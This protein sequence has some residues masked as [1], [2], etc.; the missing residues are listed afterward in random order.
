MSIITSAPERGAIRT[1]ILACGVFLASGTMLASVG[2]C[3][4]FLS[5]RT[6]QDLASLSW[7]FTAFSGGV[8]LM[9]VGFGPASDRL[10]LRGVL[11]AGMALMGGGMLWVTLATSLLALLAAAGLAGVGFGGIIAAG[12]LLVAHMFEARSATALNGV[13]VFFGVGAIVGPVIVG[14]AGDRLGL[15]QVALWAGS[16]LILIL[17]PLVLWLAGSP[18]QGG[19]GG[20][21]G[22]G[23]GGGRKTA[24]PVWILGLLLLIYTGTEVGF[25]GWVTVYMQQSAGMALADATLVASAFWLAL[26]GGR[27]LGAALGMRFTARVLLLV[28]LSGLTAGALLLALSVGAPGRSLAGALLL[29]LACG[30]VFPTVIAVITTTA[31]GDSRAAG[32]ALGI[33]NSGGLVLPALFGLLLVRFSPQA[34]ISVV[35]ACSLAMLATGVVALRDASPKPRSVLDGR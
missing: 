33:G 23:E 3:L 35:L 32:L 1:L 7:V 13:N 16:A 27:M 8:V 15:P 5:G 22:A 10:G 17:A 30:P 6:G 20:Q 11:A 14:Q 18:E 34:M 28:A 9:Q 4:P 24:S 19:Q 25:G 26:T 12:N 2:P 21:G 29:G 31:R